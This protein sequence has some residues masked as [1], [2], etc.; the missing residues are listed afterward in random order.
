MEK[1]KNPIKKKNILSD[2]T[3]KALVDLG[4][5]LQDIHN[6][7]IAEGYEFKDGKIVKKI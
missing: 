6:D 4:E 7:M 1:T 2:E 3:F 5:V